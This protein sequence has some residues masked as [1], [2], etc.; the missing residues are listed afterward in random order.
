MNKSN[1]VKYISEKDFL[2]LFNWPNSIFNEF[3]FL[4]ETDRHG[5]GLWNYFLRQSAIIIKH[6]MPEGKCSKALHPQQ[7]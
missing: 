5:C 2:N 1:S 7:I 4:M 3:I 6:C